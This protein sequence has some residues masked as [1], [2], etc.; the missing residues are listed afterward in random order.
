M[1]AVSAQ[2]NLSGAHR[3]A[4]GRL[5]LVEHQKVRLNGAESLFNRL[6]MLF[7]N[8]PIFYSNTKKRTSNNPDFRTNHLSGRSFYS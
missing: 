2:V 8:D 1:R 4:Y 6:A 7:M 5:S 3:E